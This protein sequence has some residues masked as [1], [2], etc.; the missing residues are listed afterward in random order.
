MKKGIS[1]K[2]IVHGVSGTRKLSKA[3]KIGDTGTYIKQPDPP[4]KTGKCY[5]LGKCIYN[6]FLGKTIFFIL[7]AIEILA[8]IGLGFL[9]ELIGVYK[10]FDKLTRTQ[11]NVV[12]VL[13]V[14]IFVVTMVSIWKNWISDNKKLSERIYN[15]FK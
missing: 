6:P 9:F 11:L 4:I 14:I 2:E 5:F 15:W 12:F 10:W 7:K 3:G 13:S 8:V 1:Y